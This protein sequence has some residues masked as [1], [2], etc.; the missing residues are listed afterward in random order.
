MGE[1][2]FTTYNERVEVLEKQ[3]AAMQKD[4]DKLGAE[5]KTLRSSPQPAVSNVAKIMGGSDD[6]KN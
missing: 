4:I 1:K 3:V 2:G 6:P 5:L